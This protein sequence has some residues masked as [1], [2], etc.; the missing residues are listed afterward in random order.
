MHLAN[1]A[2]HVMTG[3]ALTVTLFTANQTLAAEEGQ[4][5]IVLHV[6]DHARISAADRTLVEAEVTRIYAAAGVRTVWATGNE[7]ADAA[8]LHVRMILISRD[9]AMHAPKSVLGLAVREAR[10]AYIFTHRIANLVRRHDDDFRGILGRIMAHEVGHLVLPV[11][12]HSDEGLMRAH[13][14]IGVRSKGGRDF[15]TEQGVAIR[16]LLLAASRPRAAEKSPMLLSS[17]VETLTRRRPGMDSERR[18]FPIQPCGWRLSLSSCLLRLVPCSTFPFHAS[19]CDL[20]QARARADH[21][22]EDRL[23]AVSQATRSW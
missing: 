17:V 23:V 2:R 3:L 18:I 15:T 20:L 8:G 4:V 10:R 19:P 12:R 7:H 16:S 14:N 11:Y 22:V 6:E 5:T 21:P 9:I 13:I 1:T